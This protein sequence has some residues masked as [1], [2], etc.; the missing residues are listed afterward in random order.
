M[1][2]ILLDKH[3]L[4][5]GIGNRPSKNTFVVPTEVRALFRELS[6]IEDAIYYDVLYAARYAEDRK[7]YPD[8]EKKGICRAYKLIEP[9]PWLIAI[10][11]LM[12]QGIVQGLTWDMVKLSVRQAI[13]EL[14]SHN[15]APNPISKKTRKSGETSIGFAWSQYATNGSKQREMFLG[16]KSRYERLSESE[17]QQVDMSVIEPKN[18]KGE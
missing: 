9:T 5:V 1:Q 4:T 11:Y 2:Y 16:L 18:R 3:T 8:D 7:R 14:S 17:R 6:P 15:L 10:G 13:D 12:W